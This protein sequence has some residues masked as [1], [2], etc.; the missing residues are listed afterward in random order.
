[1]KVKWNGCYACSNLFH[2]PFIQI[3]LTDK[4]YYSKELVDLFNTLITTLKESENFKIRINAAAALSVLPQRQFY[5]SSLFLEIFLTLIRSL[6]MSK[7]NNP[8]FTEYKYKETLDKQ[9]AQSLVHFILLGIPDDFVALKKSLSSASEKQLL[10]N[11]LRLCQESLLKSPKIVDLSSINV[12]N[13][14]TNNNLDEEKESL[15]F[16]HQDSEEIFLNKLELAIQKTLL[17]LFETQ[18]ATKIKIEN[19]K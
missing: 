17:Y 9:L 14:T 2:N 7:E 12:V 15:G 13:T 18:P 16:V 11:S 1:M 19:K 10:L 5:V 3:S 8:N 6:N 4:S